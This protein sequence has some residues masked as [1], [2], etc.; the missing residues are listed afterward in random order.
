MENNSL[1]V[2]FCIFFSERGFLL[3]LDKVQPRRPPQG[4]GLPTGVHPVTGRGGGAGGSG[5]LPPLPLPRLLGRR[6]VLRAALRLGRF[7]SERPPGRSPSRA[8]RRRARSASGPAS[9]PARCPG[10]EDRRSDFG[11]LRLARYR[12]CI[13]R[14]RKPQ[15]AAGP[16]PPQSRPRLSLL[17]DRGERAPPD[18]STRA[19]QRQA[20]GCGRA[21]AAWLAGEGRARRGGF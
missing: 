12:L 18:A 16:K 4:L 1:S 17:Q 2:I 9:G 8:A 21:G 11:R 14:P 10:L 13:L 15:V 7:R 19:V 3:K 5:A 20:R 6:P